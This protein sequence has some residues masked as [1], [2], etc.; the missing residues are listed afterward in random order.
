[1]LPRS[2]SLIGFVVMGAGLASLEMSCSGHSLAVAPDASPNDDAVDEGMA[3]VAVLID[4]PFVLADAGAAADIATLTDSPPVLADAGVAADIAAWTDSPPFV[5]GDAGVKVAEID[6]TEST[7]AR[8]A[9]VVVYADASAVRTVGPPRSGAILLADGGVVPMGPTPMTF[10]AGS[11]VIVHFLQDLAAAGDV[12]AIPTR[13][14]CPKSVSF[15]TRTYI[16]AGGTQS[17]DLQCA[18]NPNPEQA[19]LIGDCLGLTY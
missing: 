6:L 14:D 13:S 1:M 9:T 4:S 5:F 17:G 3:D 18:T 15:G 2:I 16:S 7:N 12:S 8:S 11:P 19:A 10:E